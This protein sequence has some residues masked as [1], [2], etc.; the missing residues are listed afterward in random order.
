M[1]K[2]IVVVLGGEKREVVLEEGKSSS[3]LYRHFESVT[4][5]DFRKFGLPYS[6]SVSHDEGK[7]GTD[8][9]GELA[10][11][12]V[13]LCHHLSGAEP[14]AVGHLAAGGTAYQ[15]EITLSVGAGFK[16]VCGF[17]IP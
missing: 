13:V 10:T 3:P 9:A 8:V 16:I 5:A 6:V 7:P 11:L 4:P 15:R 14:I 2:R 17:R 1:S 12:L